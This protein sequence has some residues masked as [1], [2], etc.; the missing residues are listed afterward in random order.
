MNTRSKVRGH[1]PW[2][3]ALLSLVALVQLSAQENKPPQAKKTDNDTVAAKSASNSAAEG[4]SDSSEVLRMNPF[5]VS[6]DATQGYLATDTL[7]GSKVGMKIIDM[8]QTLNVITRE[9]MNDSGL[10]DPNSLFEHLLLAC[11]I[12]PARAS[13]APTRDPRFR[14]QNWSVNGA[15]THYLS[16]MVSDNFETIEAIKGPS[17]LLFGRYGG[18]GGYINVTMKTPKRNP[19]NTAQFGVGTANYYHGMFDFGQAVGRRRTSNTD[20]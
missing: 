9:A 10:D 17:V 7:S 6:Q 20:S 13:K 4:G 12:S 1:S 3:F 14:A 11:P 5:M 16:E 19:I 15:T 18:Y 8:P 2:L